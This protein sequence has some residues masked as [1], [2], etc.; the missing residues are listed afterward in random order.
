MDRLV[1]LADRLVVLHPVDQL[2]RLSDWFASLP[3]LKETD[4]VALLRAG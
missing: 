4:V 3:T 2:D 1:Q